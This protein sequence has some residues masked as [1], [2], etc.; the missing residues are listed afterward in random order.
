MLAK[1]ERSIYLA[2][3]GNLLSFVSAYEHLRA[4]MTQMLCAVGMHNAILRNHL[5]QI[6]I[7]FL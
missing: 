4:Q 5:K 2:V 6:F 7:R 3:E 1:D